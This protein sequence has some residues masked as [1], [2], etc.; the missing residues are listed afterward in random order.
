LVGANNPP[1]LAANDQFADPGGDSTINNGTIDAATANVILQA[2]MTLSLMRPSILLNEES[3]LQLK[4][5]TTFLLIE[6]HIT[7][8]GG[9][10]NLMGDRDGSGAGRVEMCHLDAGWGYYRQWD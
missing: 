3:A 7:T 8:N 4:P 10:V 5:I 9:A 2:T 1:E 6:H